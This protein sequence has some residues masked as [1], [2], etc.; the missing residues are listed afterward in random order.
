MVVSLYLAFV[1]ASAALIA[2]PGPNVAVIVANSVRHGASYG[3]VTVAGTSAAM[4]LQLFITIAG[5]SGLLA[6][7]A[8][9][10]ELLRWVGVAYLLYLGV[11]AWRAPAANLSAVQA[12]DITPQQMFLQGFVVSLTNPKTLLF[13]AAFLPQFVPTDSEPTLA[14]A[15]LAAT[16][17]GIAVVLDGF[18]ALA[19]ARVGY[20]LS[21]QGPSAN[22]LTGGI[23]L[24]AAA[25]LALVR[26]PA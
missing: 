5:L 26:R 6:L 21:A 8:H 9:G 12:Q 20:L 13:Y 23:L 18:W 10:F 15:T 11:M 19:A 24:T 17:V 14:L 1:V 22:K 4:V 16:F 25:G 7:A 3:L 2:V